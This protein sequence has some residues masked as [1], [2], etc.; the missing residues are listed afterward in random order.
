MVGGAL[1]AKDRV[2]ALWVRGALQVGSGTGEM[3]NPVDVAYDAVHARMFVADANNNRVL[4]FDMSA[5]VVPEMAPAAVLG[6]PDL[7]S[8]GQWP[9]ASTTMK[10]PQGVAYDAVDNRL[11]VGDSGTTGCWSSTPRR[12]RPDRRRYTCWAP[13]TS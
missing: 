9:A 12:S 2:S 5:G 1:T 11:F 10:F 6:Q 7:I 8:V 3:N 13:A 4:V